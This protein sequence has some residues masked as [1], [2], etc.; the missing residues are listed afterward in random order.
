MGVGVAAVEG[1]VVVGLALYGPFGC[2]VPTMAGS[3][4]RPMVATMKLV[5]VS[6]TETVALPSL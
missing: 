1:L 6:I 3:E 2:G 5:A 4:P